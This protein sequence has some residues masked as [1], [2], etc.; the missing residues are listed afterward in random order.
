MIKKKKPLVFVGM[1]GGVDSSVAALLLKKQG[2]EV[3]GVFIRSWTNQ[4]LANCPWENDSKD[5]RLVAEKLNI[6][7]FVWDFE[8]EYEKEVVKYMINTYKK[9]LTPNPDV[10]CN[11]QIKFGLFL[12][13]ALKLGAQFIATGHYVQKIK[14]EKNNFF[15]LAQSKDL[16]KDQSYFLW[17]LNQKQL[18]HSLFPIGG[19][20]K[21]EVREIA[22]KYDLPVAFK[23]DSQGVCFLGKVKLYDFLKNFIK[24]KEGDVIT[25]SGEKIGKHNGVYFYTIG[26]RHIGVSSSAYTG[27]PLYVVDKNIKKNLL[28]VAPQ[29]SNY[30]YKKEIEVSQ[31][32][33]LS[34]KLI[35][36]YLKKNELF[37][38]IYLRVRY[39]Q[40][41]FEGKILG[42]IK[43]PYLKI[44][45]NEP[46]KFI[47]PGQS[48]VFYLPQK[49]KNKFNLIG[50][51]VINKAN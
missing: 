23:K 8:K 14:D 1:S 2:Y 35:K 36:K 6:P 42:N 47:A 5:A 51:G 26:Q 45:F 21:S 12:E 33:F 29:E 17:K 15:Y 24:E 46:Q 48:A 34:E 37:L 16:N 18:K 32:N 49:N 28:I 40:P 44:I 9:G 50:G 31:V 7:F 30:L 13:R 10:M 19:Y 4:N 38:P 20:L 3:V 39:R 27:T 22:Q 41:L 25:V 11:S 43:K